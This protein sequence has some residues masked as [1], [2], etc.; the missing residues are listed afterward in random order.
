MSKSS[1]SMR[2]N[3]CNTHLEKMRMQVP[4]WAADSSDQYLI[5]ASRSRRLKLWAAPEQDIHFGET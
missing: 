5:V 4:L 3:Q 2:S 1:I